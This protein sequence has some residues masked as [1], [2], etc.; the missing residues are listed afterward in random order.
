VIGQEEVTSSCV[1]GGLAWILGKT[2]SLKELLSIGTGCP[3][4]WSSHHPWKCPKNV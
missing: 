2:S 4:K 3:G 1:R